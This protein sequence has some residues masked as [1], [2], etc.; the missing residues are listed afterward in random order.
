MRRRKKKVKLMILV[1]DDEI[2][3]G[4]ESQEDIVVCFLCGM[5]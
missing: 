3:G 1:V 4:L 5:N 2:N